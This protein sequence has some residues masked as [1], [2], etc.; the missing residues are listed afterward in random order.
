[1][2]KPFFTLFIMSSL[3]LSQTYSVGDQISYADQIQ[4][5]NIIPGETSWDWENF[6]LSQLNANLDGTLNVVDLVIYINA[7]LNGE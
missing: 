5:F 2:L 7:I 1:M 3:I 4:E 6:S